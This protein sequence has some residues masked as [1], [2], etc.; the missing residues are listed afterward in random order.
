MDS[1]PSNIIQ[2]IY[3][4]D[5]IYKITFDKQ[6]SAHCFKYNCHICFKPWNNCCCY[7]EI[8]NTYLKLC[9]QI[10]D[11]E[12]STYDDELEMINALSGWFSNNTFYT[13]LFY[14]AG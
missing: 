8:C 2:H 7:C 9:R 1:L 14:L 12:K 10:Y 4:H 13:L 11:D 6:L 3:E 5:D